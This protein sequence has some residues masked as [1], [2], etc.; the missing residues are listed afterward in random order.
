MQEHNQPPAACAAREP[1]AGQTPGRVPAGAEAEPA[2]ALE[3]MRARSAAHR[4]AA[5]APPRAYVLTFGCQQNEADSERLAGMA[6]AMGYELCGRP[7]EADLIVVNTC[8][9]REHAEKRALSTVGQYKHLKA[10]RPGLI[11]AVCGCM[12]SQ[13]HRLEELK[14]RYPYVDLAF[15][16]ASVGRFPQLLDERLA[17]GRRLFVPPEEQPPMSEGCPVRRS[18]SYRAWVSVMYGCNNFCSYCVVPYT[19]GREVSREAEPI[20]EEVRG[21]VEQ[22]YRDITLLG[23][24]VNSYGRGTAGGLDFSDL[25]ARLDAIEGDFWLRFMTSHPKDATPKLFETMAKGRHIAHQLHLPVQC[26]ND[27]VL[28]EMNRRYTVAQ[29]RELVAQA[30]SLMPDLTLSSDIIVGFPGETE[31][32]FEDTLALVREIGFDSLFTFAFS[33]RKGTRAYDMKGQLS[34]AEKKERLARLMQAQQEVSLRRN[35]LLLGKELRLLVE[36]P[37]REQDSLLQCRTE[38]GKL[39]YIPGPHS[40]IGQFV[41]A[42]VTQAKTFVLYGELAGS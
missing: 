26:G 23:Q 11:V 37:G 20:V 6:E 16:T 8:A 32:Q 12:P 17:R 38:G 35:R 41:T 4:A 9:I 19:R 1:R 40:L 29:Y 21:L 24:N 7:D 27:E 39:C 34:T 2:A 3:R 22:G 18:S 15:G 25:L 31:A 28:H 36:A 13:P 5:G 30:R 42:R 33:R 10:R 14:R